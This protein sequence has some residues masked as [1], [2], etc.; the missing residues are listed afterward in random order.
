M[1]KPYKLTVVL[2][3]YNRSKNGFLKSSLE[4][5]LKQSYKD[6]ELLVF[7]N[8]STDNT[9]EIVLSYDDP[10]LY[11]IR[12]APGGNPTSSYNHAL[13][14]SRGEYVLF[15]H[16]DDIMEPYLI[17]KYMSLLE[18]KPDILCAASNVS[19]MDADGKVLQ[20][21]L[22][23]INEDLF[24]D[25]NEFIKYYFE[26]KIWLPTPTIIYH[27]DTY[28]KILEE[29]LSKKGPEYFASGDLWA[30]FNMNLKG[31]I[32]F[33]AEPDLKYRQ[34]SEQESRNVNQSKPVLEVIKKFYAFVQNTNESREIIY[35][36]FVFLLR[37]EIQDI[38][39][40]NPSKIDLK[41]NIKNLYNDL[42]NT[43]PLQYRE[44][45]SLLPFGILS[46]LILKEKVIRK[47]V[48]NEIERKKAVNGAVLGFRNFYKK[49][50]SEQ[51][52]FADEYKNK[53]IALFGSMLVSYLIYLQAAEEGLSINNCFDSSPA[54]I[55]K[56]VFDVEIKSIDEM[57]KYLK[58]IDILVL[59][60]ESDQ[61]LAI[62]NIIRKKYP[63]IDIEV[64]SWKKLVEG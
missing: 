7:D 29:D 27:R 50:L 49:L 48:L 13:W 34:H 22:Y 23:N 14:M 41:T 15:T 4:A 45:D 59:T 47:T 52:V 56:K 38:L 53:K 36:I 39:F 55:G 64:I 25:K 10:R 42:N 3:T 16:D 19:V 28:L 61:E 31:S 63:D 51:L 44:M 60:S 43:I 9:S 12:Q 11:Y 26:N 1:K 62:T 46:N 32:V 58:D 37:F 33:L 20:K 17:S 18:R 24:F 54:R 30:V 57:G 8:Y 35:S 2:L 40:T 6:F 5:L 21:K